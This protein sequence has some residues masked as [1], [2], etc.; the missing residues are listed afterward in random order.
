MKT[1]E[2]QRIRNRGYHSTLRAAVKE[3]REMTSKED[4]QKKYKEVASLLD[5]T[6]QHHLIHHR[7]ADRNK[8]RLAKFVAT[9]T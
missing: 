8:A 2:V 3:L 9:L 1:S 4:A 7:N 6:A 5:K